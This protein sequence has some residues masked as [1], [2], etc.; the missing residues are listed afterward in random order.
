MVH[1]IAE[2]GYLK[3]AILGAGKI[4]SSLAKSF[5][6]CGVNVIATA[7]R[8]ETLSNV[9][10]L[11]VEVTRN[12]REAVVGS[13]IIVISVKP[14]QFPVL[15][16]EIRGLV[17]DKIVVSVMAGVKRVTLE[18]ALL[19]TTVYRAMPNINVRIGMS[20]TALTGPQDGVYSLVVEKLFRCAGTVYWVPEEW[21]DT[22]TALVG[23]LPAYI[24][25]LVD[26]LVL[27]AVSTGLPRDIAMKAVLDTLRATAEHLSRRDVHPAELRDEVTTPAGVT[28]E[29]LK[30]MENRGV[31][32]ALIET[33]ERSARKAE[34]LGLII[35]QRVSSN[36]A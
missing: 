27:G 3:V 5:R 22:W 23:S 4:G 2:L 30:V 20:T 16:S 10:R 9:S 17:K 1:S 36:L 35:D 8:E 28:I 19:A 21:L 29:G 25:V 6:D 24:A 18:K 34:N 15:A 33:I 14:L 11:G 12:N 26:S 7:R 32:A 31:P 13:D